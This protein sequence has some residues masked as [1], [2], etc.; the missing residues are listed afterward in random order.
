VEYTPATVNPLN[1]A[2]LDKT[3]AHFVFNTGDSTFSLLYAPSQPIW[4]SRAGLTFNQPA[5]T[6]G[7]VIAWHAYPALRS[8]ETYQVDALLSNPNL[9]QLREAGTEYPDW[10]TAKYL[11]LPAGFSPRIQQLAQEI[12]ADAETPFDKAA[13]ITSYLRNNIEY[14][15]TLPNPPRNSDKLEWILFDYKK[16]F[17]VYYASAEVT[18]L[19]SIGIPARMAVGFA[20][21]EREG[22][23]YVVRKLNA[24]AWP[25]VYF[26]GIGWVEFEPTGNQPTLDRPLPP[27]DPNETDIANPFN[28]TRTEDGEFAG[29]EQDEEGLAPT[30]TPAET[31]PPSLLLYLVPFVIVAT[32]LAFLINRRYPLAT[33]VPVLVR[34]TFERTG[35]E[36]PKWVYHWEYWGHLSPIEKAFESINFGLRT[37]DHAVPVH[38]TPVERAKKLMKIIPR[39][40]S[41]IKVLL[42]EHQTSLYTSR[43][44]NEVQ[45]H[46]AAF[47]I[48]KQVILERIRYFFFGKPMRD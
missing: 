11:Q 27:R 1:V 37:L 35:F 13:A 18:M 34:A 29:R 22:N 23:D 41:Q 14:A 21:G 45:A 44:A 5:E 48:R 7:D 31:A 3:Q 39:T 24:H 40:T 19:R 47:N 12:T 9:Q 36:V 10:I 20:Q 2:V 16:G 25:E 26:P 30:E 42:D 17:C 38:T 43:D 33:H 28:A 15:A 46:R 8:G 6:G 32:A 4:V